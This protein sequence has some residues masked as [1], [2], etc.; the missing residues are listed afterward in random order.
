[1]PLVFM[2]MPSMHDDVDAIEPSFEENLIGLKFERVRHNSCRIGKHAILRDNRVSFDAARNFH[3]LIAFAVRQADENQHSKDHCGDAERCV[4][5]VPNLR[6]PHGEVFAGNHHE[7]E[8]PEDKADS[9]SGYCPD[10]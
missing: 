3:R 4:L 8:K 5:S 10:L 6:L 7:A 1:M 9:Q 2:R